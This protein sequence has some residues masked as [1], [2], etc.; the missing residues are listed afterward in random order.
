[1][2][3]FNQFDNNVFPQMLNLF[4]STIQIESNEIRAIVTTPTKEQIESLEIE[5][6]KN[7]KTVIYKLDNYADIEIDDVISYRNKDYTVKKITEITDEIVSVLCEL[8]EIKRFGSDK[9]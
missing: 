7:L 2:F 6:S 8:L 1:M 3:Q 9:K 4:G 5:Y